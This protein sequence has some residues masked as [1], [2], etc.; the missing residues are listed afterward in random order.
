MSLSFFFDHNVDLRITQGLRL[1]LIEVLTA[2]EDGSAAVD[3]EALMLRAAELERVV[4]SQDE[5]LLVIARKWQQAGQRF[6]GLAYAHQRRIKIGQAVRD[7][8]LMGRAL[9]PADMENRVE[10]L[11]FD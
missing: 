4:F 1:R 3:D 11:P 6:P 5:D 8:E 9:E 10:Y 7:L 2:A